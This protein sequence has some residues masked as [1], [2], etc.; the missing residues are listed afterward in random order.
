[1]KY[2]S[3]F[4]VLGL[5]LVFTAASVDPLSG[6]E[7]S[8]AF[9]RGGG[10]N[11]GGNGGG[12]G[13]GSAGG[14]S[15]SHGNSAGHS[16]S[17]SHA[18]NGGSIGAS[19]SDDATRDARTRAAEIHA[20]ATAHPSQISAA[21]ADAVANELGNLNAAHASATA[22]ANA[23]PTSMVGK[24]ATYDAAMRQA[25]TISDPITR[26]Y[27]INAARGDLATVANKPLTASV[28]TRVDRLLGL[29]TGGF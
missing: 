4:L 5:G 2:R 13:G 19:R 20:T 10:G 26:A 12:H 9:A 23:A 27:A 29:P 14:N 25:L 7:P 3:A 16:Q 1:M 28:V 8:V 15:G 18:Q 17:S 11:G 24:I 22:R 6:F 21:K